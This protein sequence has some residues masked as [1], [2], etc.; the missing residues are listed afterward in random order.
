[1]EVVA[2]SGW[3]SLYSE[4]R[5]SAIYG[6]E[7]LAFRGNWVDNGMVGTWRRRRASRAVG[8][9]IVSNRIPEVAPERRPA[10]GL[11]PEDMARVTAADFEELQCIAR[12]YCR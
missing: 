8:A 12:G 7:Y 9:A 2:H 11:T 5:E 3:L 6:N 1:M 10:G 4:G